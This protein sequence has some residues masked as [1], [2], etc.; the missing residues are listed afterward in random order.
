MSTLYQKPKIF[1]PFWNH[2]AKT[3][4]DKLW[5]PLETE[6]KN[7]QLRQFKGDSKTLTSNSWFTTK[8]QTPMQ[9]TITNQSSPAQLS[10][11]LQHR[12]IQSEFSKLE[13]LGLIKK[14]D[15]IK[16]LKQQKLKCQFENQH[17]NYMIQSKKIRIYPNQQQKQKLLQWMGAYRWTYNKCLEWKKQNI[18]SEEWNLENMRKN[19]IC[20]DAI[21]DKPFLKDVPTDVR[22]E[23]L[24]DLIKN[25]KS[26]LAKIKKKTLKSFT[27]QFKSRKQNQS[28]SI[29]HRDYGRTKGKFQFLNE[30]KTA[31]PI[32]ANKV[33][34]DLRIQRDNIGN[35]YMC[36]PTDKMFKSDNQAKTFSS[37]GM[38]GVIS[39]DP[40]VRSFMTGYDSFNKN[41]I[42]IAPNDINHIYDKCLIID[43]LE[44]QCSKLTGKKRK[45]LKKAILRLRQKIRYMI[46]DLHFKV[47][48]F[49][50]L[51]YKVILL[52]IF[53]TQNMIKTNKRKI[54]KE[55]V[56][57]MVRFSHYTFRQR[58]LNKSLEFVNCNVIIVDESFTSKTC[59]NCGKIDEELKS[60]KVYNC[61]NQT[62]KKGC[63]IKMDR[64]ANGARN[65]L[66]KNNC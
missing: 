43:S 47:A 16:T 49:L 11:N 23:G 21:K 59:G 48:K 17:L 5:L 51:N 3:L 32:D 30:I 58:L 26:N 39:L 9:N 34:H 41:I 63:G 53:E 2:S 19:F 8:L 42:H 44:S 46:K 27:M 6:L 15:K 22:D 61:V 57:K 24:R 38:D 35:F 31:E 56:R 10:I 37:V 36:L 64:D 33:N 4:S 28:I 25:L 29:R 40:G 13:K 62:G 1:K 7:T 45:R 54:S 52:P 66:I 55:T 14:K 60:S 12:I 18:G 20:Q 50:C 65:I